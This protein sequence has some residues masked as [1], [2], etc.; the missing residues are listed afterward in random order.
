MLN[1]NIEKRNKCYFLLK[2]PYSYKLYNAFQHIALYQSLVINAKFTR[3]NYQKRPLIYFNY[4]VSSVEGLLMDAPV[5]R[6]TQI[7]KS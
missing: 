7:F 4:S 3:S 2:Y 6:V 5:H 1:L